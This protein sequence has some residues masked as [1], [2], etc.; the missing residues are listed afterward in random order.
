MLETQS[1]QA[2]HFVIISAT[3]LLDIKNSFVWSIEIRPRRQ[4]P[5]ILISASQ[6]ALYG[7]KHLSTL[8]GV[9]SHKTGPGLGTYKGRLYLTLLSHPGSQLEAYTVLF[10]PGTT[11]CGL[12]LGS[13]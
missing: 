9:S 13:S 5:A 4:A 3:L 11:S 2:L 7:L 8:P 1:A 10:P 12:K 6:I